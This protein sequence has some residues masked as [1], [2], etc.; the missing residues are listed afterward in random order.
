VVIGR[1]QR[2][3]EVRVLDTRPGGRP[4]EGRLYV[5]IDSRSASAAEVFARVVQRE[6]RGMV[7]GD[8][9]AGLVMRGRVFPLSIGADIRIFY[10][11]SIT[12][13]DL[14]MADGTRLERRG[15]R[16]DSLI[17]PS[18]AEL[19][20]GADPVLAAALSLAGHE[21]D[22]AS[23]GAVLPSRVRSW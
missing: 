12:D 7:L 19:A 2:R 13:A 10:G 16:P 23:A 14:I 22:P 9:S 18:A 8:L 3:R 17:L 6:G 20:A 4:V 5:L 15:V 21:T 1:I 11:L